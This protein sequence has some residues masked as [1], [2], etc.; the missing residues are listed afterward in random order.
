VL[1]VV[2]VEWD[3]VEKFDV[4]LSGVNCRCPNVS[5]ALV[6]DIALNS[7]L[8]LHKTLFGQIF[9]HTESFRL[10]ANTLI[11]SKEAGDVA[12]TGLVDA[13]LEN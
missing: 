9:Q 11:I 12:R 3:W 5:L 6:L 1:L 7:L 10:P 2:C 4:W 8:H 13:T